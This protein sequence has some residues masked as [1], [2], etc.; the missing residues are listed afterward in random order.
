MLLKDVMARD[1]NEVYAGLLTVLMRLVFVLYAE[2]RGLI[3]TSPVYTRFYSV[4]GLFERLREDAGRHPDT[5]DHRYGSWAQ[6]LSLF[7]LIH[8][9]GR[10][11]EFWIPARQGHLFDPDRYRFLE[12]RTG[13]NWIARV[14]LPHVSDGVVYRVLSNLLLLDGERLSYRTLDVEQIGS[15]YETIMGFRLEVAEGRSIAIRPKKAHG[16]PT[17]LNLDELLSIKP[18]HRAKWFRD[19]TEQDLSGVAASG[20]RDAK[21]IEELMSALDRKIAYKV[22]PNIVPAGNM[23]LQP[24]DER[25]RSGSHYTPRMLTEP[26]VRSTLKP[27]LDSFGEDVTPEELLEL[28]VCDPAMG[29]GAFLVEACRQLGDRLV[30]S[31]LRHNSVPAIPTDEDE[32]LH[33]RR[34]VAQRCIYGLDKNPMAVDLAKLSLWLVTLAKDHPF[35]FLDHTLRSGDSLVGLSRNHIIRFQWDTSG[36]RVLDEQRI[37]RQIADATGRRK[38]ILENAEQILYPLLQI[39]L[40]EAD[41]AIAPVRLIGDSLLWSFFFSDKDRIRHEKRNEVLVEIDGVLHGDQSKISKLSKLTSLSHEDSSKAIRPFHWELEFPE[42]FDR[43]NGGFDVIVGNPPFAGKNTLIQGHRDG[44]L[45]W[46]KNI[47]PK[48]HGNADLVAHFFRRAFNL[49]RQSGCFGFIATNT[50]GQGDTRST[51]LRWICEHGGMIY[52]A[53][54]RYRWPGQAAVVVSIVHVCRG[55]VTQERVLDGKKVDLISAFLFHAG[56]NQDPVKLHQNAGKSFQ[57]SIVLGMGFTFDD[58]ESADV[59]PLAEMERL[60]EKDPRNAERIFPYIGGQELNESPSHQHTR[61]VINFGELTEAEARRYPDLMAIVE[62][63]VR[64]GRLLQKDRG[65]KERWWQF[66]RPRTELHSATDRLKRVLVTTLHSKTL[67]FAFLPCDVVFSHAL[68]V[69]AFDTYTAF[70][71]LQS[72]IHETWARFLASS[73]KDDLRYTS[74]D[75]FETFPF[76]QGLESSQLERVGQEY[77]QFRAELMMRN[78]EGL[79][80]IY[81][82]FNDPNEESRDVVKLRNLHGLMD[83]EVFKCYGWSDL[84]PSCEFLLDY[85]EEDNDEPDGVS[86][87]RKPWRFR[88]SDDFHDEILARLVALN[89]K[90]AEI[91]QLSGIKTRTKAKSKRSPRKARKEKT[92]TPNVAASDGLTDSQQ[93]RLFGTDRWE[94]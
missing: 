90:Y 86:T 19:K 28:K 31:W 51:G 4:S 5:M 42:V 73:M 27:V 70:A 58:S 52:A 88:W 35:T 29:S 2:D 83:L 63:K 18:V 61:Y 67:A 77:Y 47:H 16:A 84:A 34:L 74:S 13:E 48:S 66:I 46:L 17:T 37:K 57:G 8:E 14:E 94:G 64:P 23:I 20:V 12:G 56:G 89:L 1:S 24:S 59:T 93:L 33:A 62:S 55:E 54:R 68:C 71:I 41:D 91:E 10:H 43:G 15:V 40:A 92:T 85:E 72:R 45:D 38:E 21:S 36:Q 65:A 50:I 26:I 79:T 69:F 75:C 49:L 39:R 9:G 87:R 44:Y 25:R 22:T 82:R 78:E 6:L 3:S 76:P 60:I 30:K 11:G 80:K 7:R 53:R 32:L 81:N